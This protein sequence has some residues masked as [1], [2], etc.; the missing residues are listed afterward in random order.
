[1]SS[2]W[3]RAGSSWPSAPSG[4]LGYGGP[5]RPRSCCPGQPACHERAG[6]KYKGS[7]SWVQLG[8]PRWTILAPELPVG[9]GSAV[10]SEVM[11]FCVSTV[12]E[13]LASLYPRSCPWELVRHLHL[14]GACHRHCF[15]PPCLRCPLGNTFRLPKS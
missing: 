10:P 15:F 13:T 12:L 14:A 9:G 11:V 2:P 5:P 8:Q 3:G 4:V 7:V 1:M 6:R